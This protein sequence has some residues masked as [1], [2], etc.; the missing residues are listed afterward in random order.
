MFFAYDHSTRI[1]VAPRPDG[2]GLFGI[3]TEQ[4][5]SAGWLPSSL[6]VMDRD[7]R[8]AIPRFQYPQQ[9]D[10]QIAKSKAQM[11]AVARQARAAEALRR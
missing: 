11:D 9:P 5:V 6:D 10:I 1:L 4:L 8:A 2:Q 7:L 3:T